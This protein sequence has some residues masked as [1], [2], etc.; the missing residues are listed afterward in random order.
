MT[1]RRARL[2]TAN[3]GIKTNQPS[4]IKPADAQ[5]KLEHAK[6]V[7]EHCHKLRSRRR[8][9]PCVPQQLMCSAWFVAA[10]ANCGSAGELLLSNMLSVQ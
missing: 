8:H 5:T 7:N 3:M 4:T 1:P 6:A 2:A 10:A 9:N